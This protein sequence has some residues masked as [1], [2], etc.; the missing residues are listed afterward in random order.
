VSGAAGDA[1]DTTSLGSN[2]NVLAGDSRFG[3]AAAF[4]AAALA[5][6]TPRIGWRRQALLL[7]AVVA[8]LTVFLL[9][10]VMANNPHVPAD[11]RVTAEGRLEL[12]YT[13]LPGLKEQVGRELVAIEA[14]P[15]QALPFNAL[16]VTH[17]ARWLADNALRERM[18]DTRLRVAQGIEAGHLV[19]VFKDGERV[20]V[21]PRPRGYAGLGAM[22][23]LLSAFAMVLFL[24]GWIVPLV[25]P[26]LRNLLYALMALSQAGGL[27]LAAIGSVPALTLPSALVLR[28]HS[29]LTLLDLATGAAVLHA[30]A[31]HPYRSRWRAAPVFLSWAATMGFAAYAV[32]GQ[33]PYSWWASQGLLIADGLLCVLYLA[34]PTGGQAH[35]FALVMRRFAAVT[36]GALVLLTVAVALVPHMPP[37]VQPLAA[38]GPVIWSVF[39]ASVILMVPFISRSQNVMREFAMLAGVST[40]ATSVDLL[41]VAV[42]SFSQFASLTLSLFL[43]LGAYAAVRQWLVNQMMGARTLTTER[44]FEHLYR[45]ARE[46]EAKP[47]RAGDRMADLLRH[48][49]EPLETTRTGG[50]ARASRVVANGAVLLVP[51]PNLTQG[52]VLDGQIALR[53]AERGKRLFTPEDARLADRIVEQLMRALAHDRA[54][55]RGRSEER[56]RI[57]Q[58]LHDDIG[59]RLL[60]LMYKAPSKEMEDYVRHTLQDLKTL[61]RGLAASTHSLTLAAAEWKT[62]INQRLEAARCELEWTASFDEDLT[63]SIIQ[64]SSL[65]RIMRELIS[66]IIAHSKASKVLIEM[67]LHEG[68]FTVTLSDDGVGREPAK[69]SH[70]L[71][72]GGI[73]KR[74]KLMGGSVSWREREPKGI[75]C[76]VSVPNLDGVPGPSGSG[77][78]ARG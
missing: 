31:L 72:L 22:F 15:G 48:V 51:V 6:P 49:F 62:D 65:T 47:E 78:S 7:A 71:G 11:W 52:P 64:W 73:R 40:V 33:Q 8:C 50:A 18:I 55:E 77:A 20:D 67:R 58:D 9:A 25:Q 68:L 53:F 34:W 43:A 41:F 38:V 35:P 29:L 32:V 24:V 44:M 10:R 61:T 39:F 37:D 56:Q 23:W 12:V 4:G 59:A 70:G 66:N 30:A 3:E 28:E 16:T 5:G 57:A 75:V 63:L 2:D 19:F 21:V 69:W 1:P 26:Q 45:I 54:V 76:L 14:A 36:V 74:V 17:S 42:F 27:L 46:V 60:T 13:T